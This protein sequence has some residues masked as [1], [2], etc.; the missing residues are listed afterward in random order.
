MPFVEKLQYSTFRSLLNIF[1][2]LL[3]F[4]NAEAG[5]LLGIQ[6]LPLHFSA[7]W[8][9]T[10]FALAAFLLFGYRTWS[11]IFVGNFAYNFLHLFLNEG[12]ILG[13]LCVALSVTLG[14]LLQAFVGASVIRRFAST[15]YFST[16]Q[17]V[18]VFLF[19]GGIITCMIAATIGVATL[20]LYGVL[21]VKNILFTWLTFWLGDSMGV[22]IFTPL[23]VIWS[24]Q[25]SDVSLSEYGWETPFMA[26]T[27]LALSLFT[28]LGYPLGY[29]F[30]P[31]NMW[32][33]YRFGLHGATLALVFITLV[34]ILPI[35]LGSGP[36]ILN[37]SADML[38]IV[39]SF[40]K[41]IAVTSLMFG[42]VINERN[43]AWRLIKSH[44]IDVIELLLT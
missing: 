15:K 33:T 38:L 7:V 29:L 9:A 28:V 39:V 14:S 20:Y 18:V 23:L 26:F 11:G 5:R 40:L 27:F 17:D 36:L 22:Y 19:G 44:R 8:P 31:F 2:A 13:P 42:A 43:A 32:V 35:T 10:G 24:I 6:W 34:T 1:L 30:I 4:G 12:T 3:I 41:I 21:P 37:F 16:V 25:K